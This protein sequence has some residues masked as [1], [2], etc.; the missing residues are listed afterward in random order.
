MMNERYTDEELVVRLWDKEEVKDLMSRR[1]YYK[2]N[3]WR[4]RELEELWVTE[5]ANKAS[6][7]LSNNLGYFVGMEDIR[8]YYVDGIQAKRQAQLELVQKTRPDA[9]YGNSVM[10]AHTYHTVMVEL[11]GDGQT[12]RYLCYDHGHQTDPQEDGTAKG[13]WTSGHLLAD[14]K[15]ENGVWKIWHIKSMH[16]LSIPAAPVPG[17]AGPGFGGPPPED[18]G[19]GAPPEGGEGPGGPGGPPKMPDMGPDPY[20]DEYGTPTVAKP[21]IVKWAWNDLPKQMPNTYT[22]HETYEPSISYGPDGHPDP[23]RSWR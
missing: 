23:L 18:E 4:Q 20:E 19:G 10:N 5:D 22:P 8:A 12:A 2:Q 15:K 7:S 13:Y 16:D 9:K 21:Y 17:M 6:A 3:D 1:C 11:A 14:L